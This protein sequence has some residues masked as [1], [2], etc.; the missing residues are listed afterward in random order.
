MIVV[1]HKMGQ[2]GNR[3]FLFAHMIAAAAERNSSVLFPGFADYAQYFSG[4]SIGII[5][6]YPAPTLRHVWPRRVRELFYPVG[7][8]ALRLAKRGFLPGAYSFE[9]RW[10]VTRMVDI[11]EAAF[12]DLISRRPVLC[13]G[14][15]YRSPRL[16]QKH[17]S[18]VRTYLAPSPEMA[19]HALRIER[20]IRGVGE[21]NTGER[22]IGVHVRRRDYREFKRGIY[23][24][25]LDVYTAYMR[26]VSELL[27]G[28]C[29]FV[30][31]CEEALESSA[32]AEF[33]VA[34]GPGDL[35]GDLFALSAC[36]YIIG[37]PSTFSGWA[38]FSHK[39]PRYFIQSADPLHTK[40]L[41]LSD[42]DIEWDGWV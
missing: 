16:L 42:F 35:L 6:R 25:G 10:D 41:Q 7:L 40:R 22:I 32:F 36:D 1:C 13:G 33:K 19:T 5:P 24:Y 23:F 20:N 26:R 18:L 37:P 9:T 14:F 3:L 27:G 38:S 39:K 8:N 30:V 11:G 29:R 34:L 31:C 12:L 21:R 2:L 28:Q 4:P 15:F 17:A